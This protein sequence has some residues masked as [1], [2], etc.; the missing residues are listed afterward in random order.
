VLFAIPMEPAANW[1]FRLTE[2]ATV[3]SHV[4]GARLA[5]LLISVVPPLVLLLPVSMGLW[6][7][8]IAGAHAVYV[9]ALS[10]LLVETLMWRFGRVPF[11]CAYMPGKANVR[12]LWPLY[13][14]LFTTYAYTM[15]ELELWLLQR[16]GLFAV[17]IATLVVAAFVVSRASARIGR[18]DSLLFEQE[19]EEEATTLALSSPS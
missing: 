1:V 8:G 15:A 14:T 19:P 16:P 13:L 4:A 3:R 18:S 7:P 6:G 12:L 5:L 9:L 11:T 2:R 10:W 17:S